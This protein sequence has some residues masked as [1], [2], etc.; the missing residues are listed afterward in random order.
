[1]ADSKLKKI[2]KVLGLNQAQLAEKLGIKQGTYS[3]IQSEKSN[4]TTTMKLLLQFRF[5]VNISYFDDDNEPMFL[6]TRQMADYPSSENA[7]IIG[8]GN[9]SIV[10]SS[11]IS[12]INSDNT[13]PSTDNDTI[14]AFKEALKAK[15]D[16]IKLQSKQ[17]DNLEKQLNGNNKQ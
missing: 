16:I 11:N 10:D 5:S 13:I 9:V 15:D 7:A 12:R 6:P 2:R 8:N 4:I 14:Y 1:M 17:I 3:D